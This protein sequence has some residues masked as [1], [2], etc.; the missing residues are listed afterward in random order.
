M[1]N[2]TV[3]ILNHMPLW[4]ISSLY[5]QYGHNIVC[6]FVFSQVDGQSLQGFTNHQAV[7]VLRTTGQIVHLKLIRYKH[8]P[9]YEQ[10]QQYH[11]R[12][13]HVVD[14]YQYQ[15]RQRDFTSYNCVNWN[16][17]C[18]FR[19]FKRYM[20]GKVPQR[21]DKTSKRWLRCYVAQLWIHENWDDCMKIWRQW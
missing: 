2:K 17:K 16:Y 3:A 19:I 15:R 12:L 8:G 6:I 14:L 10:L 21:E 13:K 20:I 5:S 11:G 4:H 7:D 18:F 9:K 1:F